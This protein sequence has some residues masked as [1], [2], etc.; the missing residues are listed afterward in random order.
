MQLTSTGTSNVFTWNQA[1]VQENTTII[2]FVTDSEGR[3][4]GS[5]SFLT[6]GNSS[7]SSCL[8]AQSPQTTSE[9]SQGTPTASN[10]ALPGGSSTSGAPQATVTIAP[11]KGV[12]AAAIGG[13][14]AGA[15]VACL[16][17]GSL[18]AFFFRTY[19][20]T[21]RAA[22][23]YSRNPSFSGDAPL[24]P[25][26]RYSSNPLTDFT[27]HPYGSQGASPSNWTTFS[28]SNA[29]FGGEYVAEPFSTSSVHGRYPQSTAAL[30]QNT[31]LT[32]AVPAPGSQR[33]SHTSKKSLDY[34]PNEPAR[35]ILH[36]DVEETIELPPQ[37][38]ERSQ[39]PKLPDP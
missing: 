7:D 16:I 24:P 5:S 17:I 30:S 38:R 6:V 20:P 18:V 26:Q 31:L 4:G 34:P 2:F 23:R 19:L 36:T 35:F 33:P 13:A 11:S 29:A 12:S 25:N 32:P 37:Y 28:S 10:T 1:S 27:Q 3:F 14:I 22:S 21:R 9:S 8:N 39:Q 15:L